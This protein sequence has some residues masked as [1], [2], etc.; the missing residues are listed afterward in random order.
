MLLKPSNYCLTTCDPSVPVPLAVV[1]SW[2][3]SHKGRLCLSSCCR[4][5]ICHHLASSPSLS[6]CC[7]VF[8]FLCLADYHFLFFSVTE[9]PLFAFLS[10]SHCPSLHS[11]SI[12]SPSIFL[13]LSSFPHFHHFPSY[14]SFS[15]FP[16]CSG[17]VALA[18]PFLIHHLLLSTDLC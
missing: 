4:S 11:P 16:P 10:P 5:L 12:F 15:A 18:V 13:S 8:L 2:L 3:P 6:P 1:I 7:S 9:E 14:T 17:I